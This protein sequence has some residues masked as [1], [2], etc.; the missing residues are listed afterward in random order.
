MDDTRER[1]MNCFQVIFPDMP[2]E[3]MPSASSE[4]V[5]AWDSVAVITLMSVIEEEFGFPVDLDDLASLDSFDH[6]LSYLQ[7]RLQTA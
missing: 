2:R 7:K 1:L 6:I 5:A 4:N 3:E